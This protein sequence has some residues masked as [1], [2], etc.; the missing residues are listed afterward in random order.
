MFVSLGICL[1]FVL[2][3]QCVIR[4]N[5]QHDDPTGTNVL[6]AEEY[7]SDII[8]SARISEQHRKTIDTRRPEVH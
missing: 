2:S 4:S 1:V 6:R 3:F 8:I 5:E 7:N